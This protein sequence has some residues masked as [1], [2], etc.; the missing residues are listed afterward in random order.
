MDMPTAAGGQ[1]P[2]ILLVEDDAAVRRSLQ[3]LLHVQGYDVRAYGSGEGLA[4]DPEA[5]RA[6]CLIADLVMPVHDGVEM[7][8]ELR[9]A[10]WTGPAILISGHLEG[11]LQQRA[12]D[13]GFDLVLGKP[14]RDTELTRAV[15]RL[16]GKDAAAHA[17]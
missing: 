13:G 6:A 11:P 4:A 14:I 9:A 2:R 5:L 3:L 16:M 15:A 17:R 7:L 12:K 8:R 1:R 10:G